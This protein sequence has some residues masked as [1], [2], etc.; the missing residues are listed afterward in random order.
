MELD[1]ISKEELKRTGIDITNGRIDLNAEKTVVHGNLNLTDTENGMTVYDADGI[2]SI[3]MQPKPITQI[4]PIDEDKFTNVHFNLSHWAVTPFWDGESNGYVLNNNSQIIL[5][6]TTVT[7]S[8]GV[9]TGPNSNTLN[10]RIYVYNSAQN[11]PFEH[12][13]E[14]EFT[15]ASAGVYTLDH[16]PVIKIADQND[17]ETYYIDFYLDS[18]SDTA[19]NRTNFTN[20]LFSANMYTGGYIQTYIGTDGFYVHT[21]SN[22]LLKTDADKILMQA[23]SAGLRL[24][25]TSNTLWS[26]GR[27]DTICGTA[28][29]NVVS[30]PAWVSFYNYIPMKQLGT[31]N[32]THNAQI[33]CTNGGDTEY[34]NAY[35]IDAESIYGDI[36]ILEPYKENNTQYQSWIVLPPPYWTDNDG[37]YHSLPVGFKVTIWN[38]YCRYDDIYVTPYRANGSC[39]TIIDA[40]GDYNNYVKLNPGTEQCNETFVFVGNESGGT[41]GSGGC[42]LEMHDVN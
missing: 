8:N 39:A 6:N 4:A 35:F 41:P 20:A 29:N 3:N 1:G 23:G 18:F 9:G 28:G 10:C 26:A 37:Y 11:D 14:V 5:Q 34:K 12:T 19:D 36:L 27:L 16:S 38:G 15:K 2:P 21:G 32:W 17:G 7:L 24:R 30:R 40:R 31:G 25:K 33:I 42:W 22:Q 13:I